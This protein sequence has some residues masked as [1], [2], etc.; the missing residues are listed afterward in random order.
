MEKD[1]TL[2]TEKI[3]SVVNFLN[4]YVIECH[5]SN[6]C[7][8]CNEARLHVA[9]LREILQIIDKNSI[10]P[11]QLLCPKCQSSL[12]LHYPGSY[13]CQSCGHIWMKE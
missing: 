12:V 5:P 8:R 2:Y 10:P 7:G 1:L 3:I 6:G 9:N 11:F 13:K 4:D